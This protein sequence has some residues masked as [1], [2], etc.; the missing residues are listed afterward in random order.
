LG[1]PSP[2]NVPGARLNAVSWID[3][4]GDLWLFGGQ[5][6]DSAGNF[7]YMNDLWSFNLASKQWTWVSGSNTLQGAQTAVY[8]TQGTAAPANVPLGLTGATGWIDNA[9]NLWLFGGSNIV[10]FGVEAFGIYN[11]LW[12]FTPTTG[13]WTWVRGG[14]A[15]YNQPAN[16]GSIGVPSASNDPGAREGALGWIDHTGNLWLFGGD[17]G[18]E[19]GPSVLNDLWTFNTTTGEWTWINGSNAPAAGTPGQYGTK[20]V[21]AASNVP[22]GRYGAVGWIDPSGKLWLFG[23]YGND[24]S[25]SAGGTQLNDL[26]EFD[27]SSDEWTWINGPSVGNGGGTYG[28]KGAPSP[29]N[30]PGSRY[31]AS[32]WSDRNGNL[33]IFGGSGCADNSIDCGSTVLND[34]WRYDPH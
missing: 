34:L 27:P 1:T 29:S 13:E 8:G 26:W 32:S 4:A 18:N 20:G 16:Y 10:A 17:N 28:T 14:G 24:S 5:A 7:G 30:V 33:W 2:S 12:E 9:G 21:A 25:S 31:Y 15:N 23:G 3:G 22:G 11:N 6:F 19:V